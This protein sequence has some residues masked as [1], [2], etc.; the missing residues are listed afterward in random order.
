MAYTKQANQYDFS[1]NSDHP[2]EVATSY[3]DGQKD[4][5]AGEAGYGSFLNRSI[6][7]D[8]TYYYAYKFPFDQMSQL[9][10]GMESTDTGVWEWFE[11]DTL[12]DY[13]AEGVNEDA[14]DVVNNT[15]GNTYVPAAD[16]VRLVIDD[17]D[18][19]I[20]S[21]Y[22]EIRYETSSGWQHAYV[23][24][25]NDAA[26]ST[27]DLELESIDGSN[28]PVAASD[29]PIIQHIAT[30][31]PQDLDYDPQPKHSDPTG[32]ET[33]VEN[34]RKEIKMTREERIINRVGGTIIDLIEHY[35]KQLSENFRAERERKNLLGSGAQ[36]RKKVGEDTVQFSNGIYNQ[37]RDQ[38][39][40]T[41]DFK[42]SGS[43]DADKFKSA[44][45]NFMLYNYG[46]ESGGPRVRD[47]YVDPTMQKYFDEA[48]E[49]SQRFAGGTVNTE[50][51]AGVT[52]N[53]VANSQGVMDIMQVPL[54]SELHPK[55]DGALRGG[56]DP[57]GV[58]ML[59][60]MD[61]EHV[62]RVL[63]TGQ[64][65]QQ[66][67]FKLDGGDRIMYQRMESKEGLAIRNISHCGTLEEVSP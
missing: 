42:T 63:Q 17:S 38:N 30:N 8:L 23:N 52:V 1:P 20:F 9:F 61:A 55:V 26:G 48:W 49:D 37:V 35:Q 43:F 58:A 34:Y 12:Y 67:V 18:A 28:L 60:P 3:N 62:V 36:T 10:G 64:G 25:I 54:W 33:Y 53:R 50:F 21:A 44:I 7:T 31:L 56:S 39:L 40:H 46:G 6:A 13:E 41:S 29:T 47:L 24:N 16:N 57:K 19:S 27:T 15:S 65:P 5:T 14:T 32:Y 59:L 4:L 45:Y 2:F 66:D 22:S 11:A 51:V